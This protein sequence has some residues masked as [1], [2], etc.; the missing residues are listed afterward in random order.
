M[1]PEVAE[2]IKPYFEDIYGNPSSFHSIGLTAK[3]A[4]DTAR[5]TIAKY[6][7][8][9]PAEII[10]TGSGTE[11]CNLA[12]KGTAYAQLKKGK[13]IIT[14]KTEHHAVLHSI[15]WL[16]KMHNFDVTYLDV[17]KYGLISLNEL[18]L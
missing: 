16:E 15:E 4:L 5:Y 8:C 1:R 12:I 3:N 17:D 7:N 10:F 11:S 6:L 9:K 14:Q 13:H 18:L 2:A